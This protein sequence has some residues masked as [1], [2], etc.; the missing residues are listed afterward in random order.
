MP[1]QE[2]THMDLLAA[3][4]TLDHVRDELEAIGRLGRRY[5]T[6]PPVAT[7]TEWVGALAQDIEGQQPKTPDSDSA[8]LPVAPCL[9]DALVKT[10][11]LADR[12]IAEIDGLPDDQKKAWE[13]DHITA[14]L[15]D[16]ATITG[17]AAKGLT[18]ADQAACR[19]HDILMAVL[20]T[21]YPARGTPI[22]DA[23]QD[24][25]VALAATGY[26]CTQP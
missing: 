5:N 4:A 16:V 19:A 25:I 7:I 2:P 23:L 14:N 8:P 9:A 21:G 6:L 26:D 18:P 12:A 11:R 15:R 22:A 13:D 24:A 1:D 3:M 17:D 10:S 20:K